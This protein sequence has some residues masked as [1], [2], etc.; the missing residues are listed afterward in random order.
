MTV[1]DTKKQRS[2]SRRLTKKNSVRG[3]GTG[4]RRGG[5]RARGYFG[6]VVTCRLT[7]SL[8]PLL[9]VALMDR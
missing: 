5:P 2:G 9:S 7:D 8:L 3:P 6:T 1:W 4:M